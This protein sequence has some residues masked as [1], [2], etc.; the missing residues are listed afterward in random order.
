MEFGEY[1]NGAEDEDFMEDDED[2]NAEDNWR[3]DYPDSEEEGLRDEEGVYGYGAV[4]GDLDI[5]TNFKGLKVKGDSSSD[6]DIIYGMDDDN[7]GMSFD[8]KYTRYKRRVMREYED[9]VV[10]VSSE[11]DND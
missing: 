9:E 6:D 5:G 10:S 2:S 7:D 8:N 11:S 4:G 3:N 1:R